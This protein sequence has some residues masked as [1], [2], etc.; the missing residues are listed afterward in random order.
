MF[1]SYDHA[2]VRLTG[3]WGREPESAVTTATGGKITVAFRGKAAVLHFD[4]L[5]CRPEYPHLWIILDDGGKAEAT[6]SAF[7]RVEAKEAGDHTVTVIYKGA[8]ENN[9]RWYRPLEGKVAFQGYDADQ[10]GVLPDE[11]KPLLEVIGDSI[12]EGVLID[13]FY[14]PDPKTD[15]FN[16]PYQDDVTATYHYLAAEALGL[17]PLVMGYGAVGMTHAGSGSVPRVGISYPY[18]YDGMPM[19]YDRE[20]AYILVNHGANDR[21]AAAEEY[22]RR[23]GELLDMLYEKHPASKIIALA[24]FC[25]AHHDALGNFIAGYNREKGRDV[26]FISTRGWVPEEPLHPLRDGHRIIADKLIDAMRE[27]YGL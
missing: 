15:T 8:N 2:S 26:F 12:S 17:E 20:P 18:C 21:G 13:P 4:M 10:A 19:T 27:K 3:R 25:G 11:E 14:R 5:W 9:H 7:L 1:Y 24:P 16:R 6:V 22:V 23:Y